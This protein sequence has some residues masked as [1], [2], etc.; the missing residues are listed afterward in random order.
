MTPGAPQ[1]HTRCW[2]KGKWGWVGEGDQG[3]EDF[4]SQIKSTQPRRACPL[5]G[6][7]GVAVGSWEGCHGG[8][9]VL[10]V[11]GI[12][13]APLAKPSSSTPAPPA[14]SQLLPFRPSSAAA[15]QLAQRGPWAPPGARCCFSVSQHRARATGSTKDGILGR[16]PHRHPQHCPTDPPKGTLQ[17]SFY[18]TLGCFCL[19]HPPIG[20]HPAPC[21]GPVTAV[22]HGASSERC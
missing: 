14:P 16:V 2:G 18:L 6:Y 21:P 12:S 3:K 7:N 4:G 19:W 13:A 17:G 8:T 22:P 5:R 9:E 1:R 20:Q 10:C 15:S 11:P